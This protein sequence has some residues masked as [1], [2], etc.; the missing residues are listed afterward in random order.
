MATRGTPGVLGG[1][2]SIFQ[3]AA[4]PSVTLL[5]VVTGGLW[6][7]FFIIASYGATPLKDYGIER[8]AW[9]AADFA[10]L[11]MILLRPDDVLRQVRRNLVLM[12]WPAL[13]CASTLWSLAPAS[14]LYQGIQLLL[15]VLVGLCL[16]MTTDLRRILVLLFLALM[17]A[18]VLSTLYE[19]TRGGIG[20]E[21]RG[22]FPHKNVLGNMMAVAVMAGVSL[23][24]SGWRPIISGLG[25]LYA[26]VLLALSRS[27]T[28][29]VALC[30]VISLV[31]LALTLHRGPIA[32]GLAAGVVLIAASG[33]LL[34]LELMNIG[35]DDLYGRTLDALGK[36]ETLTGR[37]I[38]WQFAMDAFD[39][40]PWLGYGYKGWWESSETSATLLKVVVDQ[41]L[42]FFHNTFLDLAVAFGVV[43]P[44][45]LV[46]GLLVGVYRSIKAFV[47][48]G[49]PVLLWPIMIVA[50]S[51]IYCS[52]D[53]VLFANHSFP[54]LLFVVA[55][56]SAL[57]AHKNRYGK[58]GARGTAPAQVGHN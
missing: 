50:M 39:A 52:V 49:D 18:A 54:Q 38:L 17:A 3:L 37:T 23:F 53:F 56:A 30:L 29:I 24:L 42:W 8:L 11:A 47:I 27:G 10:A 26:L 40:R 13:A 44:T 45:A 46:A 33:G 5:E 43:G 12:S 41:E 51:I 7:V 4:A 57:P 1:R 25:C 55:V 48:N 58:A 34:T 15:T 14:S 35:L 19:L 28:A 16:V 32:A 6:I 22:V 36:D 31:P 9:L 2:T 21:W 20:E